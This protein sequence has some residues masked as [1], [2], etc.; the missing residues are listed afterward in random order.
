M[1]PMY[2]QCETQNPGACCHTAEELPRD[3]HAEPEL[4]RRFAHG[5]QN[6]LARLGF[7][8]RFQDRR[9]ILGAGGE[10]VRLDLGFRQPDLVL[11]HSAWALHSLNR[12]I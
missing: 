2:T 11:G 12:A 9:C 3:V 6:R 8:T 5:L 7:A 4:A 1:L 10:C